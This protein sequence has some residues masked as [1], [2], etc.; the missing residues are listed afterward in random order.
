MAIL[1]DLDG[2]FYQ[3]NQVI[4]GAVEVVD[5]LQQK[6][7]PHLFITNTSSRP[8][9]ALVAK[10]AG[11]GINTDETHILTPAVAATHWLKNNIASRKVALFLPEATQIEFT[12]YPMWCVGDDPDKVA[13]VIVGDLGEQWDFSV[14]NQA[15]KILMAE[16]HPQLIALGMTRYWQASDGL[17]LDVAPFVMALSHAAGIKPLNMG[18]PAKSFYAAAINVIAENADKIIMLGDDIY[19]DIAGAQK[20]GLKAVLVQTGKYRDND[21]QQGIQP[22]GILHSVKDLPEWWRENHPAG[23]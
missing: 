9:N 15:F 19:S 8:R 18:K 21:L 22:D 5:W 11:F 14:M 23:H 12:E 16:S 6:N 2:V 1:F 17:R 4:D 7:I 20:A 13:A 10:L 3:A